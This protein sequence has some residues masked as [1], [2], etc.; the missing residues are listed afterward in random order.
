MGV[1]AGV[2]DIDGL[3][4]SASTVR[5]L[6]R[7]K[8]R[9]VCY[10]SVGTH[11]PF[12]ADARRFPPEVLGRRLRDF[13]DERWLD[14]RRIDVLA[15]VLRARLDTCARKGFDGVEPDN[16]DGYANRTGFPLAAADQLRFNRWIADEAHARD[17][18]V[19]LKNDTSQVKALVRHFDFAVVEQCFELSECRSYSPFVRAGKPVF[20]AEYAVRP[21]RF[22]AS[23]RRLRFSAIYKRLE[24]GRFRRS[25]RK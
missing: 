8:R 3:N 25:C 11:E 9:A 13:P 21:A 16:V 24:L 17:M 14:I 20:V 4:A 10:V 1:R 22:C 18:A 19:G 12:R 5:A 23:A 2:F 7:R 15:P 6:H